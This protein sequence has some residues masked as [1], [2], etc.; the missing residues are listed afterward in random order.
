MYGIGK[1]TVSLV[2]ALTVAACNA[3]GSTPPTYEPLGPSG[4]ASAQNVY[5]PT[6]GAMRAP[7]A[8]ARETVI[9]SFT[10]GADGGGPNGS[11]LLDKSGALYGTAWSGGAE[12]YGAVFK[13]TPKGDGY[14]ERAIWSAPSFAEASPNGG[15]VADPHGALYGAGWNGSVFE[16]GAQ[17]FALRVHASLRI[18]RTEE[19]QKAVLSSTRAVRSTARRT[20]VARTRRHALSTDVDSSSSWRPRDTAI[21]KPPFTSAAVARDTRRIVL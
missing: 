8:R 13:L 12:G 3:G 9:Y 15:L 7:Q 16:I 14:Q 4:S 21:R 5:L 6:G 18:G 10:G 11:L 17:G 2:A 20:M 1:L 19:P